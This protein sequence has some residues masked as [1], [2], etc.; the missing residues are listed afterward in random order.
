MLEKV[1]RSGSYVVGAELAVVQRSVDRRGI[2]PFIKRGL[3]LVILA[4]MAPAALWIIM[5]LAI[6]VKRDGGSAFY[7]QPRLGRSGKAFGLLKLRTMVPNADKLLENY[8]S[9]NAAARREWDETQKLKNDPRITAIGCFLRKYSL[10]EL[11]QLWNVAIGDMSLVG[12]RPLL[13]EQ[14]KLY[15]GTA[16]FDVRPGLTGLWQIS[17]RNGCSFAE[18]AIHDT[19]YAD[20]LSLKTDLGILLR[21]PLVMLRGTGC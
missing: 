6:L 13:Q 21:T 5:V 7:S 17:V 12:P 20:T 2:Y 1:F 3:D 11:P 19:R 18:R 14:R 8:L 4:A 9:G 16:Y 15:P 10:D